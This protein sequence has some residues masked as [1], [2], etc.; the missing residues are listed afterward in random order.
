[1][2]VNFNEGTDWAALGSADGL[3]V[4]AGYADS[5][6]LLACRIVTCVPSPFAGGVTVFFGAPGSDLATEPSARCGRLCF[7]A[8]AI[9]ITATTRVPEPAT[10]LLMAVG[11]G[12]IGMVLKP[13]RR[14]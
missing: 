7:D 1:V 12:V 4:S 8:G 2:S 3:A 9:L 14:R 5:L 11:L 10:W 6:H 13:R